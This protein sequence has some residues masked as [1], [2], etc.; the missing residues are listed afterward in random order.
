ME[1]FIL[2]RQP[3]PYFTI[4]SWTDSIPSLSV[5]FTS[6]V[7]GRSTGEYHSMN[8]A[9]HVNDKEEDVIYNRKLLASLIGFPYDAWTNAEQVHGNRIE[10]VNLSHK[11]KGRF[12]Q[13]DA[14]KGTDGLV[15]DTPGILLTSFYADCVPLYF[16][17]PEKKVI[18]LA[19]AGWKGTVLKIAEKMIETMKYSFGSDPEQ[20]KVAI[21]S[22]IGQCCYEVN[23][24]VIQPLKKTI[25][26]IPEGAIIDKQN[27]HYDLDL[28]KI[29]REIVIYAGIKPQNIEISSWCTSCHTEWFYSHRKEKGKTGRM[30]SWIGLRKDEA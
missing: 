4:P 9:L 10:V 24:E 18:G 5:G 29:N 30:A 12:K 8:M 20:I 16:L 3:I 11:G 27:G 13:D 21:G 6:R 23:E 2:Q 26:M 28:K 17:D 22:S 19:H 14:I 7:G 25:S 15:T 1:P